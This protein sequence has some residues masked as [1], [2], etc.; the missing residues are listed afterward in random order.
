[1]H[2]QRG[3]ISIIAA[4]TLVV[5]VLVVAL[6]LD[7]GRIILEK[8]RLQAAADAAALAGAQVLA[9]DGDLSGVSAAAKKA[10]EHNGYTNGA[11]TLDIG[12]LEYEN[13]LRT[14][15]SGPRYTAPPYPSAP[16]NAVRAEVA[17]S[18]PRSLVAGGLLNGDVRLS[19]HAVAHKESIALLRV[20]SKVASLDPAK[21]ELLDKVLSGLLGVDLEIGLL[22]Y[23]AL[24]GAQVGLGDLMAELGVGSPDGLVGLK[25]QLRDFLR[26]T[27]DAL[28]SSGLAR[29]T[30]NNIALK[31][32][33]NLDLAVG[34]L[35]TISNVDGPH[36][37]ELNVFDLLMASAQL[38]NQ[39]RAID[40][41]LGG[42]GSLLSALGLADLNVRLGI[43]QAPQI[44]VGPP[45]RDPQT[46]DWYTKARTGQVDLEIS[47]EPKE[48]L[49]AQLLSVE[50][51]LNLG[52]A[53][54][55]AWL[56]SVEHA[57]P[58]RPRSRVRVGATTSAADLRLDVTA[59]IL[60]GISA[61]AHAQTSLGR[62]RSETLDFDGPF[63]PEL[64][65]ANTKT[66]G[67]DIGTALAG[68][69][70]TL[71]ST[72]DVHVDLL[73]LDI[74]LTTITQALA[75]GLQPLLDGLLG[76]LLGPLLQQLGLQIGGA[77]VTVLHA[78]AGEVRLVQ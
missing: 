26:A 74:P 16:Y 60:Q 56:E 15:Q 32:G 19:A 35:L 73:G 65:D 34:E 6:A 38:A 62:G 5:S 69:L 22:G 61:T 66:L 64:A 77:D 4:A 29:V 11:V 1:M 14:F 50:L 63:E 68:G 58:S 41:D 42:A 8:Q 67:T 2:R 72:L 76:G 55:E 49:L 43:V 37:I 12:H 39:G 7:I 47:L 57:S 24:L 18:V 45:G 52:T 40:L 36:D 13:G 59:K 44:K 53:T 23:D 75:Q 54:A 33:S 78:S 20:A 21:S 27:V 51:H 46:G 17:R 25:V 28:P 30:L 71:L 70:G 10:A 9:V 48:G 31:V 3:A